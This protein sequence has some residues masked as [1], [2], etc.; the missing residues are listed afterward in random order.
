[1]RRS[2]RTPAAT[3]L[4]RSTADVFDGTH[5]SSRLAPVATFF[6]FAAPFFGAIFSGLELG[7]RRVLMMVQNVERRVC[8]GRK[9]GKLSEVGGDVCGGAVIKHFLQFSL[10]LRVFGKP[11]P[12]SALLQLLQHGLMGRNLGYHVTLAHV[13]HLSPPN[14]HRFLRNLMRL[15]TRCCTAITLIFSPWFDLFDIYARNTGTGYLLGWITFF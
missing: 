7:W 3:I 6:G 9:K 15:S 13:A 4:S 1:M 12:R 14:I 8:E 2:G 5:S 10:R 11:F